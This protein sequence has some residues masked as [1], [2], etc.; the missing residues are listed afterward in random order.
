[1]AISYILRMALAEYHPEIVK[2]GHCISNIFIIK[3]H[4]LIIPISNFTSNM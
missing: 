1:M 3:L 4:N 2:N